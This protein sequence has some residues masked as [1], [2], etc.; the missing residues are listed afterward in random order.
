MFMWSDRISYERD[1]IDNL[2][3]INQ[4]IYFTPL[5]IYLAQNSALELILQFRIL[6]N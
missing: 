5:V 3:Q 1:F 4:Y 2:Y 6:T